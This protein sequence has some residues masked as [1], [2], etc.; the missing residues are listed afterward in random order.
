MFP[1]P[2]AHVLIVDHDKATR[3][4]VCQMLDDLGYRTTAAGDGLE[5]LSHLAEDGSL[6]F[7]M[8]DIDMP[9][10]NGWQLADRIKAANPCIPIVALTDLPPNSVLPRLSGSSISHAL[11]K[12]LQLD[13][14]ISVVTYILQSERQK[15]VN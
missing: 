11:F 5:A 4:I 6:N 13:H 15:C 3:Q 14:L 12:P 8:T 1:N 10:M 9:H 7:V 2:K